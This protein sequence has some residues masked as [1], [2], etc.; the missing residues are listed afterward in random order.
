[1]IIEPKSLI[2]K[3]YLM[4]FEF[5]F[6]LNSKLQLPCIAINQNNLSIFFYHRKGT[7]PLLFPG[8]FR[9]LFRPQVLYHRFIWLS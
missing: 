9:D 1:M 4:A 2:L 3:I 5:F 8:N 6:N 7:F